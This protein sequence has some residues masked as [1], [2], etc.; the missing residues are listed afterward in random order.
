MR[1][2]RFLV[3]FPLKQ[4]NDIELPLISI[5]NGDYPYKSPYSDG[6]SLVFPWFFQSIDRWVHLLPGCLGPVAV[7]KS[8]AGG[9]TSVEPRSQPVVPQSWAFTTDLC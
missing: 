4:S 1:V 6:F 3:D 2:F 7:D 8:H 5:K 9:H